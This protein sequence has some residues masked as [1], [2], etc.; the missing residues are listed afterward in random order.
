MPKASA[1]ESFENCIIPLGGRLHDAM[2]ALEQ[3]SLEIVLV[4]DGDK[5]LVGTLTD[6]DVRRALLA[7]ATL[8]SPLA[9][10]VQ[11]VF[12]CVSKRASRTEVIDLMQARRIGQI[13]IVDH[14]GCVVGVHLLHEVAG[15]PERTQCA[16]VMAGGRGSR[17]GAITNNIPKPMLRVAGRPIL[18]RIVLHLVGFGVRRIFLSINYLGGVIEKHFGDGRSFGCSIEYLRE[19]KPL[20]TGGA[21]SLLPTPPTE[22]VLVM[23]GDLVTTAD[24]GTMLDEHM[25]VRPAAS[26]AVRRYLHRVPFGC[27]E[28]EGSAVRGIVEKPTFTQLV[29]AGIYVFEPHVIS[30]VPRDENYGVPTLIEDCLARGEKVSAF[31]ILDDWIDVGQSDSLELARG[32][33]P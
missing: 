26:I 30:R 18:E 8:G 4:V 15:S 19:E 24:L 16:I 1:S 13:P 7:N 2:V 14:N 10:F 5:R 31:E 12:T 32:G 21:L 23:N 6:G 20:G 27:L 3:S 33:A 22:P 17:L 28:V 11:R 25:R 29:N 9:P